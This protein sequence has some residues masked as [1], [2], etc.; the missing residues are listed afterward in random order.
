M[1]A[2]TN[3]EQR[4]DE[5]GQAPRSTKRER[6]RAHRKDKRQRQMA[7]AV[8]DAVQGGFVSSPACNYIQIL[9]IYS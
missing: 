8:T 7:K 6:R 3:P 2:V 4:F 5:E 1:E 9:T